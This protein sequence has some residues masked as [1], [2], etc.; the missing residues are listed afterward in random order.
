ME[1]IDIAS[2]KLMAASIWLT[3]FTLIIPETLIA[4][5]AVAASATT[6]AFNLYRFYESRKQKTN[7]RDPA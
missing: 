2:L 7:G 5:F 4:V 3:I 1:W 6:V